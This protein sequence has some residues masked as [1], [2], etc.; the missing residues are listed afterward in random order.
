MPKHDIDGESQNINLLTCVTIDETGDRFSTILKALRCIYGKIVTKRIKTWFSD[1]DNQITSAID[2]LIDAGDTYNSDCHRY[3]CS[4]HVY[5]QK[6]IRDTCFFGKGD[7]ICKHVF[8]LYV[9]HAIHYCEDYSEFKVVMISL[10]KYIDSCELS[11]E[12]KETLRGM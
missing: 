5:N 9:R 4:W 12:K 7:E 1:G 2:S 6:M 10:S 8:N 3:L 11:S